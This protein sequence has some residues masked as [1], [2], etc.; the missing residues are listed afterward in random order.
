MNLRAIT[1]PAVSIVNPMVPCQVRINTGYTV[2]ARGETIPVYAPAYTTQAQVQ[3]LSQKEIAYLAGI[4][5]ATS[6]SS[7]YLFGRVDAR[8]AIC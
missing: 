1:A 6:D 3:D 2:G 8:V 5:Q 7:V 4:N